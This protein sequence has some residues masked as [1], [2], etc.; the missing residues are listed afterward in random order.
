MNALDFIG[1]CRSDYTGAHNDRQLGQY[2]A[3]IEEYNEF[4]L[5]R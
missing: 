2:K 1:S 4:N 3:G 5:I